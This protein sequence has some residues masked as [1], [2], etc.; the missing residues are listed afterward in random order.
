M[1]ALEKGTCGDSRVCRGADK[2]GYRRV[3][4]SLC[5]VLVLVFAV[6]VLHAQDSQQ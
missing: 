6:V 1:T 2:R 3:S 4:T 5:A